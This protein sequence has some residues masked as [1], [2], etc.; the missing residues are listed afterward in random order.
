MAPTTAVR[1]RILRTIELVRPDQPPCR[2]RMAK[3]CDFN[4]VDL[5]VVWRTLAP[6]DTPERLGTVL[7]RPAP[8]H[9]ALWRM[10]FEAPI[11]VPPRGTARGA[12]H[13]AWRPRQPR[14][15]AA[16]ADRPAHRHCQ[17]PD[18]AASRP[19]PGADAAVRRR[20]PGLGAV[21]DGNLSAWQHGASARHAA[22]PSSRLAVP[23]RLHLPRAE[24]RAAAVSATR[25]PR[26]ARGPTP[27]AGGRR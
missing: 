9:I 23:A 25:G 22:D 8:N 3:E 20:C 21:Y 1:G 4:R 15:A 2:R 17:C 26:P 11:G 5:C 16:S 24:R 19:D 12:A 7:H 10:V 13:G 27:A 18:R 6:R 14:P